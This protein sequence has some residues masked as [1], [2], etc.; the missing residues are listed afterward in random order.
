MQTLQAPPQLQRPALLPPQVDGTNDLPFPEAGLPNVDRGTLQAIPDA[1]ANPP[2][3]AQVPGPSAAAP[4]VPVAPPI[5]PPAAL[6][7]AS[8]APPE[9]AQLAA[10]LQKLNAP[11]ST[12]E[13]LLDL[14][15]KFAPTAVSAVFG[16]LPAAAGAA[17][18]VNT[19]LAQMQAEKDRQNQSLLAQ[20]EA[21]RGREQQ[22]NEFGQT[23]QENK[24][25]LAQE[26]QTAAT[27]ESGRNSRNAATNS[28]ADRRILD[29]IASREK[30]AANAL[31]NTGPGARTPE[32]IAATVEAARQESTIPQR[33]QGIQQP[34][35][36]RDIPLPAAVKQ[37]RIDIAKES[38]NPPADQTVVQTVDDP[39]N[40]GKQMLVVVDKNRLTSNP[41]GGPAAK[42]TAAQSNAIAK[43][44]ATADEMAK[45]MKALENLAKQGTYAADQAMADQFFNII[46]PGSG[47]RMNEASIQRLL[48]PGP[49]ADKFTVWAQKLSKGQPLDP[50]ARQDILNAAHAVVEAK[51]GST[52]PAAPGWTVKVVK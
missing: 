24:A 42:T 21:A 45:S 20:V 39:A 41:V 34:V 15:A 36:G 17:Q 23:L 44:A 13:S 16:G 29:E 25:K 12:K 22:L 7:S 52:A 35:A 48:T 11:P 40:P 38:K 30:I 9:S 33:P 31:K 10:Q 19:G 27:L 47:A 5:A 18:G 6:P 50:A 3:V 37:D 4:S 32:G 14:V 46:K 26:G 1:P 51:Q 8:S 2:Q 28:A 43:N 49:L